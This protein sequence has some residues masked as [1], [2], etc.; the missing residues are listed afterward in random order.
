MQ[1]III[2]G[3]DIQKVKDEAQKIY[4]ENNISKFDIDILQ[5]E[6]S[7]GIGDIRELNKKIFLKPVE[8]EKKAVILEAFSGITI[9]AQNAFLKLLEEP[10]INT[11]ILILASSL[12]FVLPTV[13]SRC[14]VINSE[15]NK[16]LSQE[17]IETNTRIITS[18][19]FSS[20]ALIIA[21]DFSKDRETAL[22][23][24]EKLIITLEESVENSVDYTPAEL[25]KILR[26][27]QETYTVIKTT[28]ISPRFALEN[29][30]LN[31]F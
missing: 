27:L 20:N 22:N 10:P 29:C 30:F 7:L 4:S 3:K 15:K 23:F 18:L 21:Q 13:L 26:K 25:G 16:N 14:S 12:D 31:L 2:A 5:S 8:S 6:K 9:E 1:S 17:E 19:R 11:I 24:L 28:N